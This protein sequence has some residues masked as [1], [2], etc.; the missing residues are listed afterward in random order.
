MASDNSFVVI[1]KNDFGIQIIDVENFVALP[2]SFT[3][4]LIPAAG[5]DIT[6]NDQKVYVINS[7]SGEVAKV[8]ISS[9][10]QPVLDAEIPTVSNA[11]AY[12]VRLSLD[13]TI[14]FFVL[15]GSL[16]IHCIKSK[17][18]FINQTLISSNQITV[19]QVFHHLLRV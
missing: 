19:F 13:N 17:R 4:G 8:D 5:L 6:S 3:T 2:G 1:S 15:Q 12:A 18:I 7:V 14:G 16:E 10:V 11:G 9:L